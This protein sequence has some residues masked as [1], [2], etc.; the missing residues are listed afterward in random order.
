MARKLKDIL[1]GASMKAPRT[2][3]LALQYL[4]AMAIAAGTAD[5]INPDKHGSIVVGAL[6]G[7]GIAG[8]KSAS[9]RLMKGVRNNKIK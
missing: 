8:V 6:T 1:S 2:A 9:K 7:L 3:S 5:A 4:P